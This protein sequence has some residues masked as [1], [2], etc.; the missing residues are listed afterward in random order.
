MPLV[1]P[2]RQLPCPLTFDHLCLRVRQSECSDLEGKLIQINKL[3][4]MPEACWTVRWDER[5]HLM[6]SGPC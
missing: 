1:E 6:S 2:V 3:L 4:F 5:A